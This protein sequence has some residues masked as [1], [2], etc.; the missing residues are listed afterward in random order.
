[1]QDRDWVWVVIIVASQ[2]L[3]WRIYSIALLHERRKSQRRLEDLDR[4]LEWY[5]TQERLR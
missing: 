3:M 5:E 1:M 2:L 4:K